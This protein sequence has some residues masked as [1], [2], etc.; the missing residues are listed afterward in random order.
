MQL[1]L[2]IVKNS[3]SEDELQVIGP[4]LGAD[5]RPWPHGREWKL[6]KSLELD[7]AVHHQPKRTTIN[8]SLTLHLHV[9][10]SHL[11]FQVLYLAPLYTL[12]HRKLAGVCVVVDTKDVAKRFLLL[13]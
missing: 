11:Q 1:A 10:Q 8:T 3:P 9:S 7:P 6:K 2:A 4:P 12:V 5:V 13:C